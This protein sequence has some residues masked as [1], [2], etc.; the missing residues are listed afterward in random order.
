MT[1]LLLLTSPR[2]TLSAIG[3][4][5]AAGPSHSRLGGA[6]CRSSNVRNAPLA[7]VGIK[8]RPVVRAAATTTIF[9]PANWTLPI[10]CITYTTTPENFLRE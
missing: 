2:R 3:G 8:R 1:A 5:S 10:A 4:G 9:I 7:T 6:N